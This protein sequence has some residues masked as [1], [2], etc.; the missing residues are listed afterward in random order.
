MLMSE[1]TVIVLGASA[2]GGIGWVTAKILAAEGANVVVSA[3]NKES[4][5]VL[6]EQINGLPVTCDATDPSSIARLFDQAKKAYGSVDAAIYTPGQ[7]WS[8][9]IDDITPKDLRE[10]ADLHYHGAVYFLQQAAKHMVNGGAVTLMSSITAQHY[11]PGT[12]CYAAAKGAVEHFARYAAVEY[13]TRNIRVNCI[14][15]TSTRTPMV[16][17]ALKLPGLE[18]AGTK[19]IP[20]G[21]IGEPEDVAEAAVWLSSDRASFITGVTIP[22]DGGNHL[23][24]MPQASELPSPEELAAA[25]ADSSI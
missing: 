13:G 6:A 18:E 8:K 7:A 5:T 10:A 1:K 20:L 19:E 17:E 21:H 4:L 11:Y 16:E 2:E 22:V 15:P 3:R 24:R 23:M 12:A 25:Y 9:M 14:R